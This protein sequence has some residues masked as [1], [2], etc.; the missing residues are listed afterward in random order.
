MEYIDFSSKKFEEVKL[1]IND[2]E[3]K[4]LNQK[5]NKEEIDNI[6]FSLQNDKRKNV[7]T[8]SNKLINFMNNHDNEVERVKALYDFDKSFGSYDY[9]AGVDEVGRGP[10]A[11]P[12]VGAAVVLN[13]ECKDSQDLLL[14]INDSKKLSEKL[15]KKLSEIIKKTAVAY[16]IAVI[17]NL[18]IDKKGIAWCNN[19]VF[20]QSCNS[21]KVKPSLVLSD[22]YPIK[23]INIKNE[24]VI[25]GD[26]KSANIACASIIA[27]V[28]RDE[29][30]KNYAKIYPEY[31]FESNVGYGT[32]EHIDAIKK[33]G[34]C[35]IHRRCFLNNIIGQNN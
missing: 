29:L 31:D 26:T 8:L 15:R 22:G 25:K 13:L 33:Y 28:F 4:Y 1:V 17:D 23:N 30:M 16:N 19:Q 3:S 14:Y 5:I 35:P 9:I 32:K 20:V 18:D 24:F 34:P 10:L 2:F 6:I 11:G 27:K 7:N 12:I 21:L